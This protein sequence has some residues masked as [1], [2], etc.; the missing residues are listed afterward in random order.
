MP[1]RVKEQ[2]AN[3]EWF[4]SS[5][6]SPYSSS[7]IFLFFFFFISVG[8]WREGAV[9]P[10]TALE[11]KGGFF[12]LHLDT[13]LSKWGNLLTD[14]HEFYE[15]EPVS[16]SIFHKYSSLSI[17][18]LIYELARLSGS[19]FVPTV[20]QVWIITPQ[21]FKIKHQSRTS[22]NVYQRACKPS[23]QLSRL[24]RQTGK[25]LSHAAGP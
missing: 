6:S 16:V 15:L 22:A 7:R 1:T 23:P 4:S 25:Q 18:L 13:L 17:C 24:K 21:S 9:A 20:K 8:I 19:N 14:L 3:A 5:S 11:Y 12:F 2:K 10:P